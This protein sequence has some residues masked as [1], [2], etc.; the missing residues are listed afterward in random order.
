MHTLRHT[1]AS[2][3]IAHQAGPKTVAARLGDTVEVAMATYAHLFPDEDQGTREAGED[4]LRSAPDVPCA[5]LPGTKTQVDRRR[6]PDSDDPPCRPN[7][8]A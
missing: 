1:Y 8:A 3:L 2:V 4:F 7:Q 6:A 5:G